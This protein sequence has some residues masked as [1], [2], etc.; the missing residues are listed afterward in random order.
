MTTKVESPVAV[1]ALPERTT[2]LRRKGQAI[3]LMVAPWGFV[4]ANTC[5]AWATRNGGDDMQG[6]HALELYGANPGLV[7]L[8]LN[9]AMLGSL[10]I[11]PAVIGA[12]RLMRD[13]APRLSL[14]GGSMM[15]AGYVC[16]LAL[17]MTGFTT[18][19][20]AKHGGPM[21]D[22]AAVLDANDPSSVWVFLLFVLGNIVGTFLL[23]LGLVRSRVAPAWAAY[24]IM[25]WPIFHIIGLAAGS[26]WFEVTGAILQGIGFIVVARKV[27]LLGR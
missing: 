11:I 16:Y 12:M 5:Y 18:L 6:D 19:A 25:A 8:A 1:E 7:R 4:I 3:A 9:A 26:E 13:R 15:I 10:L 17:N 24:G 20:M 14:I 23:A 22:F 21:D 27:L 2:E